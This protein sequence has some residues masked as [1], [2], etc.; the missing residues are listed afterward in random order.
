MLSNYIAENEKLEHSAAQDILK[1]YVEALKIKLK[2][3][4]KINFERIGS[5]ISDQ[6]KVIFKPDFKTNFLLDVYGMTDVKIEP[7]KEI[8]KIPATEVKESALKPIPKVYNSNKTIRR[9]LIYSFLVALLVFIFI[10][11]DFSSFEEYHKDKYSVTLPPKKENYQKVVEK[12]IE[13]K[14]DQKSALFYQEPSKA[15]TPVITFY[16]IAGSFKDQNNAETLISELKMKGFSPVILGPDNGY[17]RVSISSF[18]NKALALEEL[19]KL[20]LSLNQSLWI[21]SQQ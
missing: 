2:I 9:V 21:L 8:R 7:E 17:Y 10:F 4:G 1:E 11:I 6:G 5:L 16:I 18:E 15:S 19:S 13:D 12:T 20:R 14:T 3:E